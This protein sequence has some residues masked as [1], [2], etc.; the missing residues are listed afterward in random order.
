MGKTYDEYEKNKATADTT[1]GPNRARF[2]ERLD[3]AQDQREL[4]QGVRA[5][6]EMFV[7]A[8]ED[9]YA[10]ELRDL[11]AMRAHE[12]LTPV[13]TAML[14]N[15]ERDLQQVTTTGRRPDGLPYVLTLDDLKVLLD[16][17]PQKS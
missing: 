16:Q 9:S 5:R 8:Y 11:A 4:L 14:R 7:E 1:P 10:P 15:M 3:A 17:F 6:V 13:Q 12:N 2:T